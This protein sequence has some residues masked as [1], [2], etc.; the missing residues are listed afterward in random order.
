MSV[1]SRD[2]T[3]FRLLDLPFFSNYWNRNSLKTHLTLIK[4]IKTLLHTN[5][6]TK[7]LLCSPLWE[8]MPECLPHDNSFCSAILSGTVPS[9]FLSGIIYALR[10]AL[11]WML[12]LFSLTACSPAR[13]MFL[14]KSTFTSCR[15]SPWATTPLRLPSVIRTQFSRWR[16]R[17]FL[18]LCSMEITSWS[19]MC[20]HPAR[21][22]ESRLGHLWD[23]DQWVTPYREDQRVLQKKYQCHPYSSCIRTYCEMRRGD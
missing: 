17:S 23:T 12:G 5:M 10:S 19:V 21:V 7:A 6:V 18:Q 3:I 11:S 20:P 9:G 1:C 4:R 8:K 13:V 2:G 16:Q 14:Q 22:S 15:L